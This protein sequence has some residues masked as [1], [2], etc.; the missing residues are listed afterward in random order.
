MR[1]LSGDLKLAG[2]RPDALRSVQVGHIIPRCGLFQG[3]LGFRQRTLKNWTFL[4]K[5]VPH[6]SKPVFPR[7]SAF[8]RLKRQS[9]I[10]GRAKVSF[11]LYFTPK[12]W[13]EAELFLPLSSAFSYPRR[14]NAGAILPQVVAEMTTYFLCIWYKAS[15]IR[16]PFY[17]L[18]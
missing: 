15:E 10:F 18:D 4:A 1:K 17:L 12:I 5:S 6:P 11:P 9:P 14:R 2:K 13:E 16:I 3:V 7:G 8:F